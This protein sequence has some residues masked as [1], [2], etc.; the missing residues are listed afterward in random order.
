MHEL[1][2][3]FLPL[4]ILAAIHSFNKIYFTHRPREEISLL[5]ESEI[6]TKVYNKC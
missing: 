5:Y 2:L 4:H 1:K 3:F 6:T